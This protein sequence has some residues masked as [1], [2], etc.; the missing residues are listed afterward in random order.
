MLS[1]DQVLD[2][3]LELIS[4][5]GLRRFSVS[6]LGVRLGVVKSALYHHFPGGKAEIVR[7]VFSRE[8]DR[9]LGA[10]EEASACATSVKE[11]LRALARAK[12]QLVRKLGHLYRIRE[13]IADE[14]EG[15]LISRRRDFLQRELGL[16]ASVIQEGVERGELRQ[17]D[18]QLLAVALQGA[19]QNLSRTYAVEGQSLKAQAVDDLIDCLFQGVQSVQ[20]TKNEVRS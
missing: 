14:L 10:M 12:I 6:E 9:V 8:E 15:F 3:A 11:R 17:V 5:E 19:L 13:E 7:E 4:R 16:I 20:F 18:A 2:R 1:R